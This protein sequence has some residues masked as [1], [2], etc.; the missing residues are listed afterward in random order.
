MMDIRGK[1]IADRKHMPG[2]VDEAQFV[3]QAQVRSPFLRQF[4]LQN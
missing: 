2:V 1:K 3:F 4:F